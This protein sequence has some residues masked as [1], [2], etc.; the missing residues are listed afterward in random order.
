MTSARER[1]GV[2]SFVILSLVALAFPAHAIR[3]SEWTELT[4]DDRNQTLRDLIRELLDS[5]KAAQWTSINKSRIEQ[6]LIQH[7]TEI[8]ID[9]NEVCTQG[10]KAPVDAFDEIL[11][12]Y[13]RSCAQ[14]TR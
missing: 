6:C 11:L 13:A 8:E 7:T 12:N 3:C 2:I 4:A 5:H 9:F 1:I 14:I 10:L